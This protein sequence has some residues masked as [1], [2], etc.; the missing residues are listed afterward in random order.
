M[1]DDN[2]LALI[3]DLCASFLT[4]DQRTSISEHDLAKLVKSTLS[5]IFVKYKSGKYEE[6]LWFKVKPNI[7]CLGSFRNNWIELLRFVTQNK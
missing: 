3:K 6:I 4:E 5:N 2:C 7:N 1:D